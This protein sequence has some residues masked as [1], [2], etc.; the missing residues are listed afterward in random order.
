MRERT[1]VQLVHTGV[2]PSSLQPWSRAGLC[3]P[4]APRTY[5]LRKPAIR[6]QCTCPRLGTHQDAED[7]TISVRVAYP[8]TRLRSG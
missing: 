6:Q 5:D 4:G 2:F 3:E 1:A 8:V 7:G